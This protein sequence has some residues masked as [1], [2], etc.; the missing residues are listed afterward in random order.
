MR[1]IENYTKDTFE[2]VPR[3]YKLKF[4]DITHISGKESFYEIVVL[5]WKLGFES[6]YRAAKAGKLDFQK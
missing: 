4:G 2:H 5:A 1:N 3:R 6:A